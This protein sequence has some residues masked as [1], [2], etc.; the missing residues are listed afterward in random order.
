[1]KAARIVKRYDKKIAKQ[2]EKLEAAMGGD[3][4]KE[5]KQ[6]VKAQRYS[7]NAIEKLAV[8]KTKVKDDEAGEKDIVRCVEDHIHLFS[9]LNENLLS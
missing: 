5:F 9:L 6:I 8:A 3:A 4:Q 1:M 7:A 2:L